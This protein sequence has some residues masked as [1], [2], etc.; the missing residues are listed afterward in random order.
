MG[1]YEYPGVPAQ[2]P[3]ADFTLEVAPSSL[4][5]GS[6]SQGQVIVTLTPNSAFT[7]SVA[8]S[9]GTLPTTLSGSFSPQ[10]VYL[11]DGMVQA[12]TL[13]IAAHTQAT[14]PSSKTA[15]GISRFSS[16]MFSAYRTLLA[17]V[18]PFG[19]VILPSLRKKKHPSRFLA[20]CALSLLPLFLSSCGSTVI[21]GQQASYSITVTGS[22][23]VTQSTHSVNVLV[24][25]Q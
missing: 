20:V 4:S 18:V 11:T 19:L 3:P 13:T 1:V 14:S 2:L 9:C 7:G 22:S 10:S 8:L 25:V 5:L 6:S 24:T 17:V 21:P 15:N 16:G 12:S 23:S